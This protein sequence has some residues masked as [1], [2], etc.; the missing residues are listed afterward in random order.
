MFDDHTPSYIPIRCLKSN[1]QGFS[2]PNTLWFEKRQE[3]VGLTA[4]G[5]TDSRVYIWIWNEW[6]LA[7]SAK[8]PCNRKSELCVSSIQHLPVCFG[9]ATAQAYL[10]HKIFRTDIRAVVSD[11]VQMSTSNQSAH[12]WM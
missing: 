6:R 4:N 11:M 1:R 2:K 3:T 12:I 7:L 10:P 9:F 5:Q 8:I